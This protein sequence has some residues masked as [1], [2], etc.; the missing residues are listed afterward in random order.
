MKLLSI[1][2]MLFLFGCAGTTVV[3][4]SSKA[5]KVQLT[6]AE[7]D[8]SRCKFLGDVAGEAKAKDIADGQKYARNDIRNKTAAMGG[9]FATLDTNTAANA[10]DYTGRNKIVLNGRAYRCK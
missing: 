6:K 8:Q 1:L 2:G 4:L 5:R 7:P 3:E 9:N 10:M